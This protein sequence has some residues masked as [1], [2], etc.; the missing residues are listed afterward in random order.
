MHKGIEQCLRKYNSLVGTK[1]NNLTIL[2][3]HSKDNA[4]HYKLICKCDCGNIKNIR[5]DRVINGVTK[6]CGCKNLNYDCNLNGLSR[7]FPALYS[8]WNTIRHRCYN[9]KN[10]KYKYYGARGIAIC[11]EWRKSFKPFFEWAMANNYRKGLSI[12]RI[13]VNGNYEPSNCRWVNNLVQA[14]NKTNNK[15]VTYNGITKCLVQ[16]CEDLN[17][18]YNTIRARIRLGWDIAKAFETPVNKI[19]KK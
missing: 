10:E 17:T 4:G 1:F 9:P 19:K 13:D 11:E 3:I 5:A 14:R 12:D 18:P 15:M 16:W 7:K 8:C 6:T 2:G